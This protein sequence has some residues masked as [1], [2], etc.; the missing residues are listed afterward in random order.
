MRRV[1]LSLLLVAAMAGCADS[2]PAV[3]GDQES[4]GAPASGGPAVA[5][6][7]LER[8]AINAPFGGLQIDGVEDVIAGNSRGCP[9]SEANG[10]LDGF[11]SAL[12]EVAWDGLDATETEIHLRVETEACR[13][14]V[15]PVLDCHAGAVAGTVSPLTVVVTQDDLAANT[16]DGILAYVYAVGLSVQKPFDVYVSLFPNATVPPGYSAIPA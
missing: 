3:S 11:H 1:V 16:A 9:F 7:R 4:G 6:C 8:T 15:R 2:S 5:Y 13:P 12:V 14:V 10:T